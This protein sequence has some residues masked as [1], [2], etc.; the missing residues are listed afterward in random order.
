MKELLNWLAQQ[1]GGIGTYLEFQSRAL[2]LRA[3]EP[4]NTAALRLM[5]DIAGRF[6]DDYDRQPLPVDVAGHALERLTGMLRQ[7]IAAGDA[8]AAER[9]GLLN[10]ISE[11]ELA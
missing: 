10:R 1:K 8:P 7:A 9:L 5:A 6:A 3:Q 11:T 4:E 2:D